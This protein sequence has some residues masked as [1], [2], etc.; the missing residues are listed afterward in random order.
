M[1]D[2][3]TYVVGGTVK[4][5]AD[6]A[7][8]GNM[9]M[10]DSAWLAENPDAQPI[11]GAIALESGVL[12]GTARARILAA[13]PPDIV[14]LTPAELR[15]REVKFTLE[16][17]PIGILFGIGVLAGLLIGAVTCYQILFTE[18]TDRSK[19]LATLFALGFEDIFFEQMVLAQALMLSIGGYTVGYLVAQVG[20]WI[21]ESQTA[22][23]VEFTS[24]AS[25]LIL[26]LTAAMSVFA[27]RAAMRP[28]ATS[29]PADFS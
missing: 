2:G 25:W 23:P 7:I 24:S 20:C 29:D 5:G 10:S 8:D 6:I 19:E 27:A 4:I 18:I 1:L 28:L 16:A 26:L 12:T 17:A 13:L 15:Q 22:M 11:M 14:V 3:K 9:V 21:I